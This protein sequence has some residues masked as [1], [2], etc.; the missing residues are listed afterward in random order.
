MIVFG[1]DTHKTSH[2]I[3]AIDEL[4]KILGSIT[5][6]N[7]LSGYQKMY[8]WFLTFDSDNKI[9]GSENTGSYG[10]HFAQFLLN[11]GIIV[12][13]VTPRLTAKNRNRILKNEKNDYLDSI[14]IAMSVLRE[15]DKLHQVQL[16]N[17]ISNQLK[18][19]SRFRKKL[20]QTRTKQINQLHKALLK[21]DTEYKEN[22]GDL[23]TDISIERIT[24][25]YLKSK[26]KKYTVIEN[27]Y[28]QEIKSLINNLKSTEKEIKIYEKKINEIMKQENSTIT[29]IPGIKTLRGASILGE[30][31]DI[32]NIK[33]AAQIANKA[34][35]CPKE[36]SSSKNNYRMVNPGGDRYL[37]SDIH[38]LAIF[39][40]G[41]DEISKAYY[42]KKKSEG[43]TSKMAIRC[44][45]RRLCDII[46]A[47]IKKNIPY[48]RL[49]NLVNIQT[50]IQPKLKLRKAVS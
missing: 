49:D 1:A 19:L 14:A 50:K 21:L 31:G 36:N 10:K 44:L 22:T 41:Y 48:K 30:L 2:T 27:I 45:M 39:L 35:I 47:V 42:N 13:E 6:E 25:C 38:E 7:N 9:V 34:G 40:I 16:E 11:K 46:Y 8:E 23:G 28:R 17:T 18:E 24:N 3:S 32:S 33:S 43:M 15:K 5:I 12:F 29:T 26:S 20:T 37:N 4:G